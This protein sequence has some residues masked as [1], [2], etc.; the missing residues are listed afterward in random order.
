[1][2]GCTSQKRKDEVNV[3]YLS[4]VP[5]LTTGDMCPRMQMEL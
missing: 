2:V 5:S 1:M 4:L 3:G